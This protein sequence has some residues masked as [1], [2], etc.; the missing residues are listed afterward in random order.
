MTTRK[1]TSPHLSRVEGHGGITLSIK[2]DKLSNVEVNIT[3]GYRFFEPLVRTHKFDEVHYRTSRICAICSVSHTLASVRAVEDAIGY[4][5]SDITKLFRHILHYGELIESN[6]LHVFALALPDF[7]GYPSVIHMAKNH[8]DKVNKGLQI[9]KLGNTIMEVVGGRAIH[10]CT[11]LTGGFSSFPAKSELRGI[12]KECME[13]LDVML[14]ISDWFGALDIPPLKGDVPIFCALRPERGGFDF[15]GD[16]I[17]TSDGVE[18][19][20][21]EYRKHISEEVMPYTTAKQVKLDGEPFNVG[22]LARVSIFNKGLTE[23][24]REV[25]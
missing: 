3:E 4:E 22:A 8:R 9:K 1:I 2:D 16:V 25:M 14:D 24:S 17:V 13:Y 23:T 20:S 6:A 5:P 21:G 12:K 11:V 10:P 19:S 15:L 7:L 18:F